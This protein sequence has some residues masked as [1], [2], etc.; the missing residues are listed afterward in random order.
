MRRVA[1]FG[2]LVLLLV[3]PVLVVGCGGTKTTTVSTT[4]PTTGTLFKYKGMSFKV[5][6]GY[7]AKV[8][9]NGNPVESSYEKEINIYPNSKAKNIAVLVQPYDSAGDSTG[10]YDDWILG[11]QEKI[12][13]YDAYI[14]SSNGPGSKADIYVVTGTPLGKVKVVL[15]AGYNSQLAKEIVDS[16]TFSKVDE[17]FVTYGSILTTLSTDLKAVGTDASNSYTTAVLADAQKLMTDLQTAKSYPAVPS[18]QAASD[19]KASLSGLSAAAQDIIDGV[20]KNDVSLI[21]R[22][23]SEVKEGNTYLQKATEDIKSLTGQ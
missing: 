16:I 4:T 17:W 5:P 6:A 8:E 10:K 13:G 15:Q 19:F 22:A 20:N 2:C 21:N 9:M 1:V 14:W 11:G 12:D 23:T 18:A 7:E 3:G